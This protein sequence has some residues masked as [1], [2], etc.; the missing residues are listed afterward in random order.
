MNVSLWQVE[1]DEERNNFIFTKVFEG[2]ACESFNNLI[3]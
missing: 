2:L 1:V 3:L